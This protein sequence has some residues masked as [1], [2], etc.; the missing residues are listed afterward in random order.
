VRHAQDLYDH[1]RNEFVAGFMGSPPMNLLRVG[2]EANADGIALVLG[3]QRLDVPT[4]YCS[5]HDYRRLT[6]GRVFGIP[7]RGRRGIG[8]FEFG[9][10]HDEG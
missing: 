6:P 7:A 5:S 1:P 10:D 8:R 2:L 3:S 4:S 9:F